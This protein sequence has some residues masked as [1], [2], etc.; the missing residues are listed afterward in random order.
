MDTINSIETEQRKY[1]PESIVS[2][3]LLAVNAFAG[4]Y[5]EAVGTFSA[6]I[7]S[8]VF[9]RLILRGARIASF[10]R[11]RLAAVILSGG[12]LLTVFFAV[13]RGFAFIGFIKFLPYLLSTY[14][15]SAIPER[16]R[17]FVLSC[18]PLTGCAQT[19]T[20]VPAFFYEPLK[21]YFFTYDRF[22]GGFG[23]SNTFALFL[24]CGLIIT[25]F[26][27]RA[28]KGAFRLLIGIT[29][30]A[31]ILFSGSRSV[32]FLL[33][34]LLLFAAVKNKRIRLPLL[35][36]AA[37]LIAG[38]GIYGAVSGNLENVARFLDFSVSEST[39][40]DR[41]LY[42]RDA[43]TLIIHRPFGLG[44]KGYQFII[45]AYKTGA[46]S[47]SFVH[48]DYLQLMLDIGVLPSTAVITCIISGFFRVKKTVDRLLLGT[49]LVHCAI[50]FDMQFLSIMLI[51]PLVLVN[52]QTT[53]AANIKR[54]NSA[55]HSSNVSKS[56]AVT[57]SALCLIAG[58]YL[59]T[60]CSFE[61]AA[62]YNIAV[63]LYPGLT[64]SQTALLHI[65]DNISDAEKLADTIIKNNKYI[66]YAYDIKA[67]ISANRHNYDNALSLKDRAIACSP[68]N[69]AEYSDKFDLLVS[70]I[71]HA[72]ETNDARLM[73][74]ACDA[75]SALPGDIDSARER[76]S[77]LGSKLTDVPKLGLTDEKTE[78]ILQIKKLVNKQ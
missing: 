48:C 73:R 47:V 7:L 77:R 36:G 5:T 43:L 20:A 28:W 45:P 17:S 60:A 42:Y 58:T 69:N 31:G 57:L 8:C 52:E 6:A 24:L 68:L 13:D 40:L 32:F 70:A 11:N 63:K 74:K 34:P 14:I 23:Y 64:L 37:I 78:Y 27:D 61:C 51:L 49:I 12:Y 18:I 72:G 39:Y 22:H 29:L 66:P 38:A 21:S 41:L 76:V 10:D 33:V 16:D 25:F 46:Y 3:A 67:H 71:N 50:D 53:P 56:I 2:A 65:T 59:C 1:M 26:G 9:L 35:I 15:F 55:D 4:R 75:I 19:L 30:S 62:K 44:Y 54:K